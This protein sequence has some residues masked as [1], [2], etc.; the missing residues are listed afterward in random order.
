[1]K[2]VYLSLGSNLGPREDMLRRALKALDAPELIIQ[3]V[4][5]VYETEPR[6]LPNQPWFLNLV[7]EFSSALF[8]LQLLERIQRVESELGRRRQIRKGPRTIDIDI[9]LYGTL[10]IETP[11]LVIPHPRLANRRFV[12]EPLSELAPDLRLP[13]TGRTVAKMLAAVAG[14]KVRREAGTVLVN[15]R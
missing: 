1:V 4:S 7:A 9:L 14:Q 2:T 12:L 11:R 6:D 8:P 10:V 5:S 15:W 3:R 13:V